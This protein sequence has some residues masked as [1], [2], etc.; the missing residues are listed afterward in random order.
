[1]ATVPLPKRVQRWMATPEWRS[2]CA[3]RRNV[4]IETDRNTSDTFIAALGPCLR[5]PVHVCR[6]WMLIDAPKA[7]TLI[8]SG[9]DAL[10][11]RQQLEVIAW[12]NL[13]GDDVQVVSLATQPVFSLVSAGR[14]L[15]ALYYRLNTLYIEINES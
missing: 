5:Q 9:V 15:E 3:A 11:A 8:L 12:L 1:M 14:F 2:I 10:T 4:L 6:G 7:G 13:V